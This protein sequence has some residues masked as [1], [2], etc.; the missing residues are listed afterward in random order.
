MA[1]MLKLEHFKANDNIILLDEDGDKFYIVLQ[2]FVRLYNTLFYKQRM[3]LYDYIAYMKDLFINQKNFLRYNRLMDKNSD[4]RLKPLKIELDYISEDRMVDVFLEKEEKF[5]LFGEGFSFGEIALIKKS[6][7]N[8]TIKAETDC[9]L[10]S[11]GKEDYNVYA[12]ENDKKKLEKD[13]DMFREGYPIIRGFSGSQIIKLLSKCGE[14][15]CKRYE[16]LFKQNQDCE[17]LYFLTQGEYEVYTYITYDW[18]DEFCDYIKYAK[19]NIVYNLIGKGNS[20]DNLLKA[21]EKA[22]EFE[23]PS[24]FISADLNFKGI[25]AHII[26]EEEKKSETYDKSLNAF[27]SNF[28]KYQPI[29]DLLIEQEELYT[30]KYHLMKINLLKIHDP[31]LVGFEDALELKKRFYFIECKSPTGRYKKIKINNFLKV[32]SSH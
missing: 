12:R 14:Y 8:T 7:R 11:I 18:F 5:L 25:V 31:L 3:K 23:I 1:E 13:L 10:I 32:M 9:Y 15:E 21:I 28:G 16:F 2:G 26:S 24:P 22:K 6:K 27:D 30:S 4:L 20:E 29:A 19:S 17:Y